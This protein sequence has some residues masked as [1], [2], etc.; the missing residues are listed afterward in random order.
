MGIDGHFN[1]YSLILLVIVYLTLK[2]FEVG[3]LPLLTIDTVC[4]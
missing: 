2:L 4:D 3:E 1:L